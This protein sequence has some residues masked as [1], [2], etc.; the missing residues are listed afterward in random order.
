MLTLHVNGRARSV[1][2]EPDMPL[3]ARWLSHAMAN[4]TRFWGLV[5]GLVV[6]V[7]STAFIRFFKVRF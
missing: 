2:V 3:L 5:A 1:D 6:V 7:T 4:Q